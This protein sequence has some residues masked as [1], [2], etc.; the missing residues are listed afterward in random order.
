MTVGTK[1][2][3]RRE[4]VQLS[5]EEVSDRTKIHRKFIQA[6]ESEQ[7]D[8]LPGGIYTRGFLRTYAEFLGLNADEIVREYLE[9]ESTYEEREEAEM[10]RELSQVQQVGGNASGDIGETIEE[11]KERR[12]NKFMLFL[13]YVMLSLFILISASVIIWTLWL[14]K[15]EENPLDTYF[16]FS[17]ATEDNSEKGIEE[18]EFPIATEEEM[19]EEVVEGEFE[20]TPPPTEEVVMKEEEEALVAVTSAGEISKKEEEKSEEIAFSPASEI[21]PLPIEEVV[22][23]AAEEVEVSEEGEESLSPVTLSE[24]ES[25]VILR[26]VAREE[27][28]L[29]VRVDGEKVLENVLDP[30]ETRSW[31]VKKD[32]FIRMGN[33]GGTE[34]YLNDESVESLGKSGEVTNWEYSL[35]QEQ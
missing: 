33:A 20:S 21:V 30:G 22:E 1:L 13:R 35:P 11:Y 34:V 7:Y 6:M 29:L 15:I 10:R 5:W 24:S 19:P 4:A 12:G 9:N 31:E 27:A 14:S 26:I 2:K 28:W 23:P 32:I 25:K 8:L 17:S 3:N 18:R 16:P